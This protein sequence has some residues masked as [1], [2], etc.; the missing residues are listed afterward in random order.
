MRHETTTNDIMEFLRDHMV[1]KEDTKQ[2]ATKEDI[3]NIRFEMATKD[4]LKRFATKSD[5]AETESRLMGHI[6]GFTKSV[7]KFDTELA[8]CNSRIERLERHTGITEA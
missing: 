4:D 8:A 7:R 5:L 3:A 6:D 2:F 1:T